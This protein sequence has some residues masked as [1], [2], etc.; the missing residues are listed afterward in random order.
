MGSSVLHELFKS[1]PGPKPPEDD[2]QFLKIDE[3][4]ISIQVAITDEIERYGVQFLL[5]SRGAK[6]L[7]FDTRDANPGTFGADRINSDAD[8]IILSDQRYEASRSIGFPERIIQAAEYSPESKILAISCLRGERTV[9]LTLGARVRQN[10]RLLIRTDRINVGELVNGVRDLG[11]DIQENV[12]ISLP[13]AERV[14][15]VLLNAVDRV[16]ILTTREHEILGYIA[17]GGSNRKI[18]EAIGISLR[19]VNNHAGTLFLKLG[20][21]ANVDVNAR[22]TASLAFCIFHQM[23]I[24]TPKPTSM[25]SIAV[26]KSIQKTRALSV[27]AL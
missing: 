15:D 26:S 27:Q 25:A 20:I 10:S 17:K 6:V 19:T 16:P 2:S 8:V 22:V 14:D 21:N 1:G 11:L 24:N 3:R 12:I 7:D 4:S 9:S 18:A 23:L 13:Y 5:K